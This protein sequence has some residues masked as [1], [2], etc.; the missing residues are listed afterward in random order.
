MLFSHSPPRNMH[1]FPFKVIIILI[2]NDQLGSNNIQNVKKI[3]LIFSINKE[4]DL[5]AVWWF[6]YLLLSF[7]ML[8]IFSSIGYNIVWPKF[9]PVDL[10][11]TLSDHKCSAR[12]MS[13]PFL[14]PED[15]SPGTQRML[16]SKSR[17]LQEVCQKCSGCQQSSLLTDNFPDLHRCHQQWL[18]RIVCDST[19]LLL[20]LSIMKCYKIFRK[21]FRRF[22]L[23]IVTCGQQYVLL[24]LYDASKM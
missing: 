15:T 19:L 20:L 3:F 4:I 1:T 23:L 5:F 18:Q 16:W 6:F 17:L 12:Q 2:C 22:Y 13:R 10:L 24:Y 8:A 14:T 9:L 21:L 11:W 7:F